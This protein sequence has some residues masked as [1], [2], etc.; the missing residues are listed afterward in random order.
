MSCEATARVIGD[1]SAYVVC[2]H[3]ARREQR[4]EL[5]LCVAIQMSLQ[6]LL[7]REGRA[8]LSVILSGKRP[9]RT[10]GVRL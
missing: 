2:S 8:G 1:S 4:N 5:C 7:G 9:G 3:V 10:P 6:C